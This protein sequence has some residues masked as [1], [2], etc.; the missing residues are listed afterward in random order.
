M[1]L[2]PQMPQIA[3]L[4]PLDLQN[5]YQKAL[6][7][8]QSIENKSLIALEALPPMDFW[9]YLIAGLQTQK[10]IALLPDGLTLERYNAYI[11]HLNPNLIIKKSGCSEKRHDIQNS[12]PLESTLLI[13]TGGSGGKIK[14]AY[15]SWGTLSAAAWTLAEHLHRN[16]SS[17]S[18]TKPL[19]PLHSFTSLPLYHISGLMPGIRAAVTQGS[20]QYLPG[21]NL[22]QS[23]QEGKANDRWVS[24]VPTQLAQVLDDPIA[25]EKLKYAKG[26]FL[27]GARASQELLLKAYAADLPICLSYGMTETAGMVTL[28]SAQNFRQKEFH[29]GKPLPGVSLANTPHGLKVQAKSLFKGYFPNMPIDSEYFFAQDEASWDDHHNLLSIER[30]DRFIISGGLKIDPRWIESL[31]LQAHD[32]QEAFV[33]GEPNEYWGERVIACIAPKNFEHFNLDDFVKK[34]KY[35]LE[36]RY[37]PKA[38]IVVKQLPKLSNGKM[39]LAT[40]K[41]LTKS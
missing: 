19:L 6:H 7:M 16:E 28:S 15:H 32:I 40:L 14:F 1:R 12:L 8:L 20:V 17:L 39:D 25:T 21:K 29:L 18:S 10:A 3:G 2:S 33:F 24:L 22:L 23:L 34:S 5:A 30:K 31:I 35:N 26:I 13:S 11:E 36:S 37:H 38:W 9:S 4:S 27:G 41:A